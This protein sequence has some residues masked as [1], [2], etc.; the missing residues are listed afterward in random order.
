MAILKICD[1]FGEELEHYEGIDSLKKWIIENCP[2][3][4]ETINPPYSATLNNR[5]FP[6]KDHDRTLSYRDKVILTIEPQNPPQWVFWVVTAISAAYSYYVAS[7]LPQ[8]YQDTARNGQSIYSAN[9]R[10]NQPKPSGFIREVSGKPT[11]YPDYICEPRRAFENHIEYLHLMLSVGRGY[12]DIDEENLYIADT[13]L[14]FY[15]GDFTATFYEP[16][17]SNSG[18]ATAENW[19]TSRE[20]ANLRLTTKS[21][22][23]PGVWTVD[24]SGDTI[25]SYLDGIAEAFPFSVG[26]TFTIESGTNPGTYKVA[27][28]S[29]ASSET[30]TVINMD[31]SPVVNLAAARISQQMATIG[32]PGGLVR[33]AQARQ[34][35]R[36]VQYFEGS[37]PTFVGATGE[38]TT[39]ESV[40]G[41]VVWSTDYVVI[42]ENQTARYY[43]VDVFF[44]QGLVN[45]NDDGDFTD[46]TVEIA[47]QYRDFA[48]ATWTTVS[49]TNYTENTLDQRG[50]TVSVDAGSAIRGVFRFRRVTNDAQDVNTADI[51]EIA[52]VK[53]KLESPTSYDE[54]TTIALKLKGTN[55]LASTAENKINIRG[56]ARKLPT[57]QEIQDAI[58]GTPYDLSASATRTT[59]DWDVTYAKY[60]STTEITQDDPDQSTNDVI[61][62]MS[63]DG[64]K[65]LVME[66]NAAKVF[67]LSEAFDPTSH[68]YDGYLA[69]GSG[70]NLRGAQW[71]SSGTRIIKLNKQSDPSSTF[72]LT[73]QVLDTAYD[74]YDEGAVSAVV[75][76]GGELET[77][78]GAFD[79]PTGVHVRSNGTRLWLA[80]RAAEQ[81]LQY[82]LT[83]WDVSTL[84]YD[85]VLLDVTGD[86]SGAGIKDFWM[87]DDVS[88]EPSKLYILDLNGLI[89]Q[90][91]MSTPGD[92]TTAALQGS[93]VDFSDYNLRAIQAFSNN[94][95]GTTSGSN[96]GY[97]VKFRLGD[98]IDTRATRSIARFVAFHLYEALGDEAEDAI[99]WDALDTLDTL[100]ESRT[101]YLDDEFVDES[102]L[103][104]AIKS[105]LAPG[106]AEPT[107]KEGA[108][109]PVRTATGSDYSH[110]YT[111]DIMRGDGLQIDHKLY[112]EQEPDGIDVEY[113]S[114]LTNSM[115]VVECRLSG[116]AG[117]RTKR[118]KAPGITDETKAW[119]FGMRERRR[120]RYK[121][122]VYTFTTE[123][124]ALNSNYG[125]AIAIA[126]DVFASQFGEVVDYDAPIVTLDF[127]P[128]FGVGTHYAAFRNREGEFSGLY[129]VE[130]A[131]TNQIELTS[132]ATLDFV[133][134]TDG[135][136]DSTLMCFGTADEIIKRA[137][138]KRIDPQAETDVQVTAEEYVAEVFADDNNSPP[139]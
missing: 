85:S 95:I 94:L 67:T 13:P 5:Y 56:A 42:P 133:P 28:L 110:L 1:K 18:N 58:D 3:Y 24:F 100:W 11:I 89:Y 132:P 125:D 73:F 68:E 114:L 12:F 113:F 36:M 137:I 99:D 106:Y 124:D 88:G 112:D 102:T 47:I 64:L 130:S 109:L 59:T 115:E 40:N 9:A 98:P 55:T 16:G 119:R 103:W 66:Q 54:V 61:C 79:G 122:A 72:Q 8:T 80:N 4:H 32:R 90:Y 35:I 107:I 37:S 78:T 138:V 104:D 87:G 45:I 118:I 92:I 26:E 71:A 105:A 82:S 65:L 41:G 75:L 127:N 93:A 69:I 120:L 51:V 128:V 30:A 97:A 23:A 17:D 111:P 77:Y 63:S 70:N 53:A 10:A 76:S 15:E 29:G 50:Y 38:E 46:T 126:S 86:L 14:V 21:T 101:D 44:P 7:N 52:R 96:I 81:I 20:I 74:P 31:A 91:E 83:A 39:W 22:V 33:A 19:Y 135:S 34:A 2:A 117:L 25:T 139:S 123:M 62:N 57:L 43:E 134:V 27:S 129:E 116:D 48:S 136:M 84:S 121:P 108:F 131:G 60:I 6:H 49:S